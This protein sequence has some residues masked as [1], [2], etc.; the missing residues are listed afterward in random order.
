M[1]SRR[2]EVD[3]RTAAPGR[4]FKGERAG[5]HEQQT[6]RPPQRAVEMQELVGNGVR[7][8]VAERELLSVDDALAASGAVQAREQSVAR[9]APPL[10]ARRRSFDLRLHD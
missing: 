8:K 9:H 3:V 4:V 1:S 5:P 6:Q 2:K 10:S 7:Q